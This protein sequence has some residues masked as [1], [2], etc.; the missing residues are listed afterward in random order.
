[1]IKTKDLT[2]T[3]QD[4][5]AVDHLSFEVGYGQIFAFLGPSGSG[6]TTTIRLLTGQEKPTAGQFE[7]MNIEG[8]QLEAKDQA[9]MGIVSDN[10][11]YYEQL[12][13]YDNLLL[14]AKLYN[15][16]QTD[17]DNLLQAIGLYEDRSTKAKNL[18]T[19]MR[20]RMFLARALVKT[21][22]ILFLDEPTSGLD[23]MTTQAI[24]KIL[25]QL[26]AEGT[27]IFLTTHDM[28]EASQLADQ[29][30]IIHEGR[31]IESGSPQELIHKYHKERWVEVSFEDGHQERL[32]FKDLDQ[33]RAW[34]QVQ[35]IHSQEPNL[36]DI[37]MTLTGEALNA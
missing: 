9:K 19:G 18:S 2:K 30:V 17:L 24:H 32:N 23:P 26:R 36:E 28:A 25:G 22:E 14:Y 37:F 13:L 1:M 35:T 33:F 10:N 20:Q 6:K 12:S 21:P 4:K 29:I 5:Q 16:P 34:D 11:G 27:T 15:F 7:I 31:M 3:Y 8:S